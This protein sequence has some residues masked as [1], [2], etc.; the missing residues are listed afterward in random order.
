M[1]RLV[2]SFEEN[3]PKY[4]TNKNLNMMNKQYHPQHWTPS[5]R[6]MT[7]CLEGV[8]VSFRGQ[9]GIFVSKDQKS[10]YCGFM[11]SNEIYTFGKIKSISLP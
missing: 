8:K 5:K 9:V 10:D 2:S 6:T 3:R 1:L 4:S 11:K 7:Y